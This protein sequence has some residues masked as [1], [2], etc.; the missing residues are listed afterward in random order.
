MRVEAKVETSVVIGPDAPRSSL[1]QTLNRHGTQ[2]TCTHVN[3]RGLH[4]V[5]RVHTKSNRRVLHD[6]C[7][8]CHMFK[9]SA[10]LLLISR[11]A[12]IPG[13]HKTTQLNRGKCKVL[14]SPRCSNVTPLRKFGCKWQVGWGSWRVGRRCRT[15][16]RWYSRILWRRLCRCHGTWASLS[17]RACPPAAPHYGTPTTTTRH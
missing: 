4:N 3:M 14:R 2:A 5:L 15:S 17:R 10:R 1:K 7:E 12:N 16:W 9:E 6:S 13:I 11:L 8:S